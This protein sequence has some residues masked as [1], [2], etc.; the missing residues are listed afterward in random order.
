M[1]A[2]RTFRV[3]VFSGITSTISTFR[4]IA[5]AACL[6]GE[7]PFPIK[8]FAQHFFRRGVPDAR[9][10]SKP[11]EK[12]VG[13]ARKNFTYTPLHS[14]TVVLGATGLR[15]RPQLRPVIPR[16]RKRRVRGTSTSYVAPP[17]PGNSDGFVGPG[18][19]DAA[20]PLSS[21]EEL[22]RSAP[23]DGYVQTWL[24]TFCYKA[25]RQGKRGD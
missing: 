24:L 14:R 13:R 21:G 1:N 10:A 3:F 19:A 25:N 7:V 5:S 17:A 23:R 16:L 8:N 22:R 15:N 6:S 2:G 9:L 4:E 12:K 18:S 20:L 11:R